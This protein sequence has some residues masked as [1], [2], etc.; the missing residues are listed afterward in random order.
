VKYSQKVLL[1]AWKIINRVIP[2]PDVLHNHHVGQQEVC[3]ICEPSLSQSNISSGSATLQELFVMVKYL[4]SE[5]GKCKAS[6]LV[7]GL[8]HG[9]KTVFWGSKAKTK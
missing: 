8:N 3:G 1:F 6:T 7:E 5:S 4:V 9:L 2:S